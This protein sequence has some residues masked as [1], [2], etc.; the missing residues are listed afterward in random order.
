[1]PESRGAPHDAPL[2]SVP[3]P[4]RQA[5]TTRRAASRWSTP[6]ARSSPAARVAGGSRLPQFPCALN[7]AAV[8]GVGQA[9]GF[10][11]TVNRDRSIG[12]RRGRQAGLAWCVLLL[13]LVSMLPAPLRAAET[14]HK[15]IMIL[16]SV[17]REFRPWNE[18]ARAIR[19]ELDR[20]S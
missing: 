7:R 20:Q 10:L 9:A 17:G 4:A 5:P 3:P 14:G 19:A 18:Y 8:A 12:S 1:M 2:P 15:R 11:R 16:H 6:T 13:T